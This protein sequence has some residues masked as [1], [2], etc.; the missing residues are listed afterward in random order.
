MLTLDRPPL[1]TGTAGPRPPGRTA[2]A[3]VLGLL[4][5]VLAVAFPFLPVEQD[6]LQLRWPTAENGTA[7]VTA[8]LVAIRPE[9][10]TAE[11]P[12]TTLA[13]LGTGTAFSTT[14]ADAP[15][16]AAVGLAV[17]VD[18]GTVSVIGDGE[19]LAATP[20]PTTPGCALSI[21]TDAAA[22]TVVLG[23]QTL[24]DSTDDLRP[25]VVGVY[26]DLSDAQ[27]AG[28]SV[29]ITVDNRYDSTPTP[30]KVA[31]GVLAV[32]AL[33]GAL[34]VLHG[35]DA[36]HGRRLPRRARAG[37]RRR[38]D[39]VRD[40]VVIGTLVVWLAFGAVTA[41]DGYIL[42]MVR[43]ASD[44][45]YVGNYYRWFD[46]P[47]A[48]FG[49][50]YE[51]YAPWARVS[52]S[53]LWLR[54][55]SLIMGVL[56]W[57][58]L[59]RGLLP[60]LGR[61]VRQSRAAGWAAATVFLCF[62]LP[63]LSGLRP[64]PVVVLGALVAY[65]ALERALV[66]RRLVPVAI[67]LVAA[68]FAV[69]ATP[70]GLLAVAPFVAAARPLLGMFR[71][72]AAVDGWAAVL[73][74]ILGAGL[75]V[76][77]AVFGDQ[78]V[79]TV[80]EATR[81]RTGIGPNVPWYN[82]IARYV[83]LF[84]PN[85]DGALAR[86]FPVLLLVLCI[87]VCAVVILRRGAIP[88]AALGPSRRL[89]AVTLLGF[90]VLLLTPTKWTH[91]FG[92]FAAIGGG[93]GAL[94]ALATSAPVLRSGRNRTVFL[95]AVL[96]V[97]A[98]AFTGPNAWMY[99]S[100]WG[101][102]WFDRPPV[103]GGIEIYQVL[104]LAAV[105]CLAVAGV[106][107]LRGGR[108]RVQ[109]PGLALRLGAGPL[110]VVCGALV[111]LQVGSMGKA[112]LEQRGSY[113][114]G[115]D[116]LAT[117]G[118]GCGL[119]DRVLVDTDAGVLP[120]SDPRPGDEPPVTDGFAVGGVPPD[121]GSTGGTEETY[122]QP[123]GIAPVV[124]SFR[125]DGGPATFRSGWFALPPDG[126]GTPL[127]VS[128]AGRTSGGTSVAVEFGRSTALGTEVLT[129]VDV[130]D[131]R[132]GEPGWRDLRTP[133]VDGADVVRVIAED[134]AVG[135]GGWL[136]VTPP[137]VPEQATLTEV[138]GDSP[139]LVD[140]PVP[141]ANPCVRPFAVVDGVAEVP[142]HRLLADE[143]LR[144]LGDIWSAAAAGGPLAWVELIGD[145][146]PVP[147][148]LAGEP[149]RDWGELRRI[150]LYEPGAGSPERITGTQTRW[151]WYSPGPQGE[152][153]AGTAGASR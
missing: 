83:D 138:L 104:L 92:A 102:P 120:A 93:V 24:V 21:S 95:A 136:A 64:E 32:L 58:L 3:A 31:V 145:Q 118:A 23:G 141:F 140:W 99:V 87:G 116:V 152:P 35:L 89:I 14:P 47:E 137:R 54:L 127:A 16:G 135:P 19:V 85:Q 39:P 98:I 107:N 150:D 144:P 36:R 44:T 65:V 129:T 96:G 15:G 79:A 100:N 90:L 142:T 1:L 130:S 82:E 52:D 30:L 17:T 68:A 126:G 115:G 84:A 57:L 12:C 119:A 26:S 80:L 108:E 147:S 78:T 105:G 34:A 63:F 74:P 109:P 22:T 132:T 122:A 11:L 61:Q 76:L 41:D 40:T 7:P 71:E 88:G 94:A 9:R 101:V 86:R 77:V 128:V 139:V 112:M 48:P 69:G 91:H 66:V 134:R 123:S 60:R 55:P 45:G 46:V 53:V 29:V 20:V 18:A 28:A 59:S 146:E 37:R 27:G 51:L 113:S 70:T 62:W 49:W 75:I 103:I 106:G 42:T 151:G 8:P 125:P 13:G 10:L 25:E 143:Q 153:P 2:V 4:A 149:D 56:S 72:R 131:E 50:F 33:L 111:A 6:T 97:A 38:T 114:V 124:G 73:A 67:G 133:V 121:G 110:V 148:Y 81:V 43:A 5:A 117:G